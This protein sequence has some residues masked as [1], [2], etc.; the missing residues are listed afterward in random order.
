MCT[1]CETLRA[2]IKHGFEM[3]LARIKDQYERTGT[4]LNYSEYYP[5]MVNSL[6]RRIEDRMQTIAAELAR[7]AYNNPINF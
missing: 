6:E 4:P 5:A 7:G 3:E 2:N 1:F